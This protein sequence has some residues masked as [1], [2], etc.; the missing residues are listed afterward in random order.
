MK[1]SRVKKLPAQ[2]RFQYWVLERQRIKMRREKGDSRPWTDDV[3]LQSY[4]FCNVRRMS[5]KVSQW[6]LRNWYEPYRDHPM[7]LPAVALAR[8]VNK[9]ESLNEVTWCVFNEDKDW[10]PVEIVDALREYRDDGHTVFNGAYMV[11]GNDGMDKIDCVVNH[12][13]R[14]LFEDSNP[15]NRPIAIGGDSIQ[16]AHAAIFDRYGFGSF[17]A[18]QI[19]ADLRWA[20]TGDWNDRHKWAAVGPGSSRG[21]YRLKRQPPRPSMKQ[22]EFDESLPVASDLIC[23]ADSKLWRRLEAIDIQNCLCEFDKYERV[24]WGEGKPKQKYEGR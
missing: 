21:M 20:I 24:L 17:M 10:W 3:I 9:P 14:H 8:F 7:I 19:V 4:R 5:D 15:K 23:A 16:S 1:T 11:R 12:Y 13:I 6:L 22:E 18:G 2:E